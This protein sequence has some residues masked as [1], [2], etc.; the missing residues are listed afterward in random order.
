MSERQTVPKHG[1]MMSLRGLRRKGNYLIAEAIASSNRR[2]FLEMESQREVARRMAAETLRCKTAVARIQ[3]L[4]SRLAD[5]V[6]RLRKRPPVLQPS[7]KPHP[8]DS[9]PTHDRPLSPI[10]V[11]DLSVRRSKCHEIIKSEI[12][13]IDARLSSLEAKKT[14]ADRVRADRRQLIQADII[15]KLT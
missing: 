11:D 9:K 5:S 1:N 7:P 6:V 12:R 13:S 8:T 15:N 3:C 10:L 14:A 4:E 2:D